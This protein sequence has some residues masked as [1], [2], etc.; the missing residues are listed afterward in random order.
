MYIFQNISPCSHPLPVGEEEEMIFD[1]LE[2]KFSFF[3]Y[4]Y[5]PKTNLFSQIQQ[6]KQVKILHLAQ[7]ETTSGEIIIF[8]RGGKV[9]WENVHPCN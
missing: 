6:K 9:F 8:K 4:T 3:F 2:K 7:T 1:N 5:N